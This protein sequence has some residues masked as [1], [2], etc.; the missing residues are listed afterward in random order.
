V[1]SIA[2]TPPVQP[3][4]PPDETPG[5]APTAVYELEPRVLT[6]TTS[7][8]VYTAPSSSVAPPAFLRRQRSALKEDA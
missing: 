2:S 7:D 3:A 5:S 6:E 4:A 1:Q 8:T